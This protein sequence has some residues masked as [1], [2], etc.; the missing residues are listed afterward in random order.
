MFLGT[1]NSIASHE[2]ASRP[3]MGGGDVPPPPAPTDIDVFVIAGQSN[4]A[5]VGD[6][7]SAI[8]SVDRTDTLYYRGGKDGTT[9]VA[10]SMDEMVV[11]NKI[12]PEVGFID[13][14]TSTNKIAIV[15]WA[16]GGTSLNSEWLTSGGWAWEGFKDTIDD[17][18]SQLLGLNY[19]PTFKG[20]IWFQGESD[21]E[22][23]TRANAYAQNLSSLMGA[24]RTY[25]SNVNIPLVI[26]GID[27]S[28]HP[29]YPY[30]TTVRDAQ[31]A[32]ANTQDHTAFVDASAYEMKADNIHFSAQGQLDFGATAAEEMTKL[33][34]AQ[35]SNQ[36]LPT[37][38][39]GLK[40]WFDAEA[41]STFTGT[42]TISK[43]ENRVSN[44][45]DLVQATS[46]NQ[47][48]IDVDEFNNRRVVRSSPFAT[49]TLV[50]DSTLTISN[51]SCSFYMVCK[52][53]NW[54]SWKA[55]IFGITNATGGKD[56]RWGTGSDQHSAR[57]NLSHGWCLGGAF[58]GWWG[59]PIGVN[60]KETPAMIISIKFD[61]V[62]GTCTRIIRKNGQTVYSQANTNII[63]NEF[64]FH[65][66]LH[67]N[68]SWANDAWIGELIICDEHSDQE[69][70]LVESYLSEKWGIELES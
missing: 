50:S 20:I 24:M 9:F 31:I 42:T 59:T 8:S 57:P 25:L 13:N 11:G 52:N 54:S 60:S 67:P 7:T 45:P 43:W 53:Y 47:P 14:F 6:T 3:V 4:A 36:W 61:T 38:F 18:R 33:I 69:V 10:G 68:T 64:T 46:A 28:D 55:P 70:G 1:S 17:A 15:K 34:A 39:G 32:F 2:V 5:G 44:Q 66:F 51:N 40:A 12:G 58:G 49:R 37:N 16:F 21:S 30:T 26:A 62:S 63:D 29:S 35:A 19:E 22:N 23:S 48:N 27:S 65:T 56:F 41:Y